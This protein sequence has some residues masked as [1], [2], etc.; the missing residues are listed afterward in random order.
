MDAIVVLS[1]VI[2]SGIFL[3]FGWL[4]LQLYLT[5]DSVDDEPLLN[6]NNILYEHSVNSYYNMM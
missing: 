4:A 3:F 2:I 5:D 1:I 6:P